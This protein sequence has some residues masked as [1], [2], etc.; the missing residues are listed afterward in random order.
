[1][2]KL[3]ALVVAAVVLSGCGGQPKERAEP[4]RTS[5]APAPGSGS[6]AAPALVLGAPTSV[7]VA[8]G[9][10]VDAAPFDVAR[11]VTMPSGWTAA[12][13]A[14]VE[15]ARFMTFTPSG[16]LLVSQPSQGKVRVVRAGKVTDFA[17]GLNRP[18]DMVFA[19]VGGATW[20]FV[21][22]ADK[23][24][25]YPYKSGDLKAQ[26]GQVVVDGLPDTST[27]EL[28]GTY[29]HV[30]K[31]IAVRGGL[32]YVSIASTCN[33]CV[34]DTV[35]D[36]QRAAI[37]TYDAAGKN[38][39][40]HLMARG[41]RNAEGLAFR[42]DSDELWVVVNNRDN[43][44]V[45]DDRDV[46]GDGKSDKGKRMSQF[47]D[48]YPVEELIKVR[49]GGFYGWPFCNPNSDNGTHNLPFHRDYELNRDG[50]K[51]DCDKA[52]PIDLG[53]PAHT[54]PL[55]LTFVPALGGAV[56][57][58]HGSWNSTKPVGYKVVFVPWTAKGPG[59]PVDLLSGLVDTK[60]AK[61]WLRP[62]DA[63]VDADGSILVSDDYAG[64]ILR[65]T[66]P[67]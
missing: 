23:V 50:G 41:I 61:P 13:Y 30:L 33:A 17:T 59:D 58:M 5:S 62:V 21:A 54:A 39:G 60:A 8:A 53:L 40:K 9:G 11:T 66:P 14:R 47:V 55:G 34:E 31:N 15:K 45:P 18:H 20:L 1:M 12:V 25:R 24:V 48:Q 38:A 2:R 27:P 7:R 43:T 36:P 49:D 16:D 3:G 46:D 10:S 52:D 29:A 44:L 42:P 63:A 28:R 51:A 6:S 65:L 64:T 67:K 35:S 56:I 22:E 37:Y 19:E 32:L 26:G 57:P 4:V